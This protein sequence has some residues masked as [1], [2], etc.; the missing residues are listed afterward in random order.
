MMSGFVAKQQNDISAF[1]HGQVL[2]VPKRQSPETVKFRV[3]AC[4]AAQWSSPD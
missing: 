1:D 3:I 4:S 2:R